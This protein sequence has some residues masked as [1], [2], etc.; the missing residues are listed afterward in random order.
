MPNFLWEI[1]CLSH[2]FRL[3]LKTLL[4]FIG[5]NV[6]SRVLDFFRYWFRF[7]FNYD[8]SNLVY[9]IALIWETNMFWYLQE[10]EEALDERT[11]SL[12]ESKIETHSGTVASIDEVKAAITALTQVPDN[13]LIEEISKVIDPDQDGIV[14]LDTVIKAFEFLSDHSGEP[15]TA[16]ALKD[17][18]VVLSKEIKLKEQMATA[19]TDSV[20]AAGGRGW[21]LPLGFLAG[22]VFLNI[23][24]KY[25]LGIKL[26]LMS[27]GVT[28]FSRTL[29]WLTDRL[30]AKVNWIIPSYYSL[31]FFCI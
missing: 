3:L 26:V 8:K 28:F 5:G 12:I 16:E 15:L 25:F 19:S 31:L 30:S 23:F 17:L 13:K 22:A 1:C 21:I 9:L 20:V 29:A 6:F 4:Y 24:S 10:K 2:Y 18:I 7:F 27:I 11:V 14:E